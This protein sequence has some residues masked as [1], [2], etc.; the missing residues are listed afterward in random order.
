MEGQ[1]QVGHDGRQL[2]KLGQPERLVLVDKRV[3]HGGT[4]AMDMD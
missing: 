1:Q 4:T 2:L 3:V